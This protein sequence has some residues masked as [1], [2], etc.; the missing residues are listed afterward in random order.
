ML[1]DDINFSDIDDDDD[2]WVSKSSVKR[3]GKHLRD[4]GAQIIALSQSEFDRLPFDDDDS[5]KDVCLAAR[6]MK[7]HSEE[8]RREL[9]HIESLL[10]NRE[11]YIKQYED[12][13][14]AIAS[15]MVAGNATF[16]RLEEIRTKLVDEGIPEINNLMSQHLELDRQKL[17]SLVSKAQKEMNDPEK[18][19]DKK[20]YKE[21]FKYLK[22]NLQ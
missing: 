16:H 7:P 5:L 19:S 17:R 18:N 21:L 2:N 20:S 15:T 11:D 13:L 22:Q 6:K 14:K 3:Y 8:L 1:Q 10:R 9:L 4:I 12:A